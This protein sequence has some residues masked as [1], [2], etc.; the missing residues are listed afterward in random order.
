[1]NLIYNLINVKMFFFFKK[2][3]SIEKD[4][5]SREK[6]DKRLYNRDIYSRNNL[7]CPYNKKIKINKFVNM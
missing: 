7:K 5:S 3:V 4:D 2:C 6:S 1:M